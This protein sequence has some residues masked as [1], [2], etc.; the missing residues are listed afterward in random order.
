MPRIFLLLAVALAALSCGALAPR[1]AV[2]ADASCPLNPELSSIKRQILSIVENRQVDQLPG[3]IGRA[4]RVASSGCDTKAVFCLGRAAAYA[5]LAKAYDAGDAGR[6]PQAIQAILR[7]AAKFGKPWAMSVMI[8]DM[9]FDQAASGRSDLYTQAAVDLE[10]ALNDLNEDDLRACPDYAEPN[11]PDPKEIKRIVSRATEAKLLATTFQVSRTRE[12]LCGGVFLTD[13]RGFTPKSTPLPI[14]FEFDST[15]FTPKGRQAAQALLDCVGQE[16]LSG[17]RLTGH[18]DKTGFPDY[19]MALSARRLEAVKEFL[20]NGG[21]HG[22][23]QTI[24]RGALDPFQVD[25]VTQHS[26]AEIDQL[27]RRVELLGASK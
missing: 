26:E 3:L 9:E 20:M 22:I 19:N 14:E 6:D 18:T 8:G 5:Y 25:D 2:A 16:K 4:E 15:A 24:P 1:N 23:I 10:S 11:Y 7:P 13:I 17:I 27:N 12:G 21:Y